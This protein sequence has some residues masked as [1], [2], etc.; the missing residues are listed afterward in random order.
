MIPHIIE[1]AGKSFRIDILSEEN[2]QNELRNKLKEETEEYLKSTGDHNAVKELADILE[3]MNI[4]VERHG[5]SMEEVE[6]VRKKK[7]D[8][9]GSFTE[10]VFL[11]NVED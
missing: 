1:G 6:R 10:R 7:A 2:F 8:E 9:K 5:S 11:V 3:V 4:L